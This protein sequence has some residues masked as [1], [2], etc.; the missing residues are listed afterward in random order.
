MTAT[1]GQRSI[2][3]AQLRQEFDHAFSLPVQAEAVRGRHLLAIRVGGYPYALDPA[4]IAGLQVDRAIVPVPG[5]LPEWLGLAGIRGGLVPV[6]SL[7]ALLG[8]EQPPAAKPRWLALCGSEPLLGLAFDE[9][10]RHLN[11][12]PS[13]IAAADPASIKTKHVRAVA[14]A[15]LSRPVIS[16]PSVAAE[17]ARR[18]ATVT[19]SKEK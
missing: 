2:F 16:I 6:Y 3:A 13:Q 15:D 18:C 7:A 11:L 17:I 8:Y 1:A 19:V 10:E 14:Q 4:E 9:F 5:L 12:D